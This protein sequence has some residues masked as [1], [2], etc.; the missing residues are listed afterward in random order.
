[1]T[2]ILFKNKECFARVLDSRSIL[3]SI[4][5]VYMCGLVGSSYFVKLLNQN[6]K[7]YG[8]NLPPV[9]FD[10]DPRDLVSLYKNTGIV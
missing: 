9:N 5:C 4:I 6:S 2:N 10:P 8:K 3:T 7:D 1:M